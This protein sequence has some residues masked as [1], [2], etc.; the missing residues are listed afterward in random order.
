MDVLLQEIEMTQPIMQPHIRDYVCLVPMFGMEPAFRYHALSH[1]IDHVVGLKFADAFRGLVP[2]VIQ[3]ELL[4]AKRASFVF[5]PRVRQK[6]ATRLRRTTNTEDL[7]PLVQQVI[8]EMTPGK[9]VA[10][11]DNS[12]LHD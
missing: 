1:K 11:Q 9:G 10:S 2:I 5:V 4:E 8:D 6:N 7:Q 3:V 12:F